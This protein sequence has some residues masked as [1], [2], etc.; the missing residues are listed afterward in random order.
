MT[1]LL[2]ATRPRDVSVTLLGGLWHL[3]AHTAED[4]IGAIGWDTDNLTGVMPGLLDQQQLETML[5][6][7][8]QVDDIDSRW[9][10]S[11][12]AAVGRAGGRDWW[13]TVNLVT[14]CL[15]G[16][17]YV[18]GLLLHKGIAA[19]SFGFPDWIDAAYMLLWGRSDEKDRQALDL[20]L[21]LPPKNVP[22]SGAASKKMLAA[23]AAD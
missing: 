3:E 10:H 4:W 19:S 22:I 16:W 20:R 5:E 12:R 8:R 2:R 15:Q 7:S 23:F 6:L 14:M 1:N 9:L 17:P 18:N 13:W 11:G 21:S